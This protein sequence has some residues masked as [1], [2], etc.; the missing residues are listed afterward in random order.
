MSIRILVATD[1]SASSEDALRE[2]AT[3][4]D[5]TICLVHVMPPPHEVDSWVAP[6]GAIDQTTAQAT[7]RTAL[8][9]QAT[10]VLGREVE[11]LLLA[12]VAHLEI[13]ERAASWNA[14]IVML[15]SH[16]RT[17][18]PRIL[19]GSVAEQVVKRSPCSV[20]IAR[21]HR[22]G[23]VVV[24]VD[25]SESSV[26]TLKMAAGEA[27]A[28]HSKLIVFHAFDHALTA[29]ASS[30]LSQFLGVIPPGGDA[31][32][33]ARAEDEARLIAF[34]QA[35]GIE[36]ECHAASGAAGHVSVTFAEKVGASLLVVGAQGSAPARDFVLGSVSERI[37]R[38]APC[39]LLAIRGE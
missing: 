1:M 33:L 2:A 7:L 13:T 11:V 9:A 36:A 32:E 14:D 18:V 16:G 21:G 4:E 12:G 29:F 15:G 6:G 23:P 10:T 5:A 37:I 22:Q 19:L 20:L 39:S 35:T 17:G 30:A 25:L 27:K 28:R 8:L 26:H 3:Y 38:T 34:V 24:A 31:P